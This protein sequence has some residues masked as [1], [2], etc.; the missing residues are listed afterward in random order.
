MYHSNNIQPWFL[1]WGQLSRKGMPHNWARSPWQRWLLFYFSCQLHIAYMFNRLL[2]F[3]SP[4]VVYI[5]IFPWYWH[6]YTLAK[7]RRARDWKQGNHSNHPTIILHLFS[8]LVCFL[9]QFQN[10][11]DQILVSIKTWIFLQV[12]N[13]HRLD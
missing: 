7:K 13:Y 1:H 8:L 2:L 10:N 9:H 5:C 11:V 6:T 4:E 12:E 3:F